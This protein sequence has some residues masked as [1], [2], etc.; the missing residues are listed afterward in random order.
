[1]IEA[2]SPTF[3]SEPSI[4]I[5]PA[6]RVA[7]ALVNEPPAQ[8]RVVHVRIG[9]IEIQAAS[10]AGSALAVAAAPAMRPA[11]PQPPSGF[12]DFVR[13]RRYSSWEG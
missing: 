3:E 13:L 10:S 9:S 12:D 1:L 7:D 2:A 4:A 11:V 6:A 5:L 8:E